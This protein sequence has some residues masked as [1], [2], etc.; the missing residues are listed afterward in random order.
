M[1][2]EGKVAIISLEP[3]RLPGGN[4]FHTMHGYWQPPKYVLEHW[5]TGAMVNYIDEETFEKQAVE[6]QRSHFMCW[7]KFWRENSL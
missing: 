1:R 3:L 7:R 4:V 5:S 2:Y 6:V